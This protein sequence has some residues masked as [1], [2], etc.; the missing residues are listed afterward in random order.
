MSSVSFSYGWNYDVFLSFRGSDT[1]HG[2]TGHLYKALCDRGIHTFID[3]EELQRGEEITPSLLKA[4]QESRIAIPVFSKNYASSTFCLDELVSIL[5]CFKEKGRLVLPVFYDVDPSHVRHQIG[6]YEEAL[7]SHK[8]RFND[9]EKLQKWKIALRQVADLSGYHFKHG[10]EN[11]YEFIGKIVIEVSQKINRTLLH[12]ADYPVG[13]ESPLLQVNSLL[14]IES[15]GVHVVGIYGIGGVGKTTIARAIYNLIADQFEGLCFLDNVRETSIKHGL[16]HLQEAI[17]SKSIGEDGIKLGSV[18]EGIP[19]IKHRLHLKKVLLVLD[20]VDKLD[21]LQ[22]TVGGTD[23]FGSGSRIIITTRDRHLLKSHGVEKTYEVDMLNKKDAFKLLSWSAFKTDKVDSCYQNILNRVVTFTSGLPLALEVIGSNLFGKRIEEW[24]SALDRYERIP[25]KKIQD[26]LRVSFDSLEEDEQDIFLDIACCFK[27]YALTYVKEILSNHHGFRPEYGIGVLIDKSLVKIDACG[28]VTLHDLI[29]DMGKEIVRKESPEEPGKRSR[30]W[31][32]EDIVEVLEENKGTKRIQIINLDYLKYE[33]EW[34]GM[35]FKEMTNLKTLIIRDAIF[36]NG[37]KHL[38][39]SLRVLE[40]WRYP[41]SSLPFEFHPK[42]LVILRL[43]YSCF[44]SR[45]L[46]LFMSKKMFVNTRVLNFNG[47]HYITEI[48][49]VCGV[50]NLQELSFRYCENLIKIHESV[51]FLDK[52]KTLDADGCSKLRSF[53]PIKLTSL[54]ELCLTCCPSLESFPKILGKMDSLTYLCI[55]GTPIKELPVSIQNLTQLGFLELMSCGIVQL[56]K[57]LGLS[58][59]RVIFES[60]CQMLK[61]ILSDIPCHPWNHE[62]LGDCSYLVEITNDCIERFH[63]QDHSVSFIRRQGNLLANKLSSLAFVYHDMLWVKDI[64]HQVMEEHAPRVQPLELWQGDYKREG[65][66][67]KYDSSK[68]FVKGQEKEKEKE[69]EK[70]KN[71]IISSSKSSDIKCFK[72]LGRGHI[73]SQCP[74]KKIMILRGQDIYSSYD[75]SSSITTSDSDSSDEDHQIENTYPYDGQLLMIRRLLGSQPSESHVSQRENI[76]HTRCNILDKACSLI[77]DSGLCCNCCSTRLVEKL[78]LTSI[79]HPKPYQLHWLNED[80][81]IIVDKQVKVKGIHTFI[82]DEELQSGEEITPS[83]MKAIQESRIAIPVFSKNYACSPFCLDEL[84]HILACAKEKGQLVLPVFYDVEPSHV[85]DS[86]ETLE[87]LS[88]SAFGIDKVDP[89][90]MTILNRVVTY[91][92]GL[93]LALEVIGSNLFR[94]SIEECESDLDQYERIP[95]KKIQDI[96]KVS[97]DSLEEDEQKIFL[98]I[99]CCF[100]GYALT[101]VKEILSS[102]HGFCPQYCIGVLI[103]KSLIKIDA[104]HVTLHDLIEDM[105]KEIVRQESPGEPGKRSRLW[106]PEDIAQVLEENKNSNHNFGTTQFEVVKWDGMAF[107]EMGNL[108]SQNT[109]YQIIFVKMRVLNFNSCEYI[110]E[111]PDVGGVPNLQELS[112]RYCKNLIKIHGLVGFLANL[113]ILDADGCSKL[114]SFPPIKLTSLENLRLSYCP[115]LENFPNILGKMENVTFLYISGTPIKELPFSFKNLT[116]LR[117]FKLEDCG[118]IQF[119]SSIF[120]MQKLRY[121]VVSKC[122][123]LLLPKENKGEEQMSSMVFKNTF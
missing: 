15:G 39:N 123:G 86:A 13:L 25:N 71:A 21:Q 55:R 121:L 103:D 67:S 73:A 88:W 96:L 37:P 47:C 119:P 51:G 48:P 68:N 122:E 53:P 107:K 33:V 57:E 9:Q 3:D 100:K 61:E 117:R 35:G 95:H 12:V 72:C 59:Q 81:D 6:N 109:Y 49:D 78:N 92:A 66:F 97:F 87:L 19:I 54:Q 84:V 91:A 70:A 16:V 38:P 83:L 41:S 52:L 1:R 102:H 30:L 11:E 42:K 17:L 24:E 56:P 114:R 10:G 14:N 120:V 99:A 64:P 23:W 44:C 85:R 34:N 18:N 58:F 36:T 75:E 116:R 29:E 65:Q 40:W 110:T 108:K 80:R 98:D 106:C 105:G 101:Y 62:S 45:S 79:P 32:P 69:K 94:R 28:C 60:D 113:K 111:I 7:N 27:G 90:F 112:F 93:P 77:V 74:N 115:N 118:I 43:P 104:D 82:D 4:I 50:P 20:D 31:C 8:E 5:A 2:F 76:F 22:A 89:C 46:D 26:I 63:P